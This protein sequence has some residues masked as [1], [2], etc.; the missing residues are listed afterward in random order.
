M[1]ITGSAKLFLSVGLHTNSFPRSKLIS[2]NHSKRQRPFLPVNWFYLVKTFLKHLQQLRGASLFEHQHTEISFSKKRLYIPAEDL[3]SRVGNWFSTGKVTLHSP[4]LEKEFLRKKER[5]FLEK[6]KSY[7]ICTTFCP[8]DLDTWK[9]EENLLFWKLRPKWGHQLISNF[10]F[11]QISDPLFLES[12]S[13]R[14]IYHPNTG[15]MIRNNMRVDVF[16]CLYVSVT[17]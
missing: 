8:K 13:F 2:P 10:K 7:N 16:Y 9:S 11:Y 1:L 12:T 15:P 4:L 17:C 3:G 5:N 14:C 6:K